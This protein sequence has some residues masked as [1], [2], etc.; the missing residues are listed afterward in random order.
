LVPGTN[1]SVGVLL[2]LVHHE[3]R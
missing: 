1:T 2:T 3:P